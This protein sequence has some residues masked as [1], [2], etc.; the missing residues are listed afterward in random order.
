[1]FTR[2]CALVIA[3]LTF[4]VTANTVGADGPDPVTLALEQLGVEYQYASSDPDRGFDCS[5]L[6]YYVYHQLGVELPHNSRDQINSVMPVTEPEP[7]DLVWYPGHIMIY[8]G[9]GLIVH[10]P[11]KGDVVRVDDL[12]DRDDLKFGRVVLVTPL[13]ASWR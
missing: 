10:A 6:V 11:R 1:M 3:L 7:G 13:P 5:G 9:K 2:A 12:P 4:S 8:I